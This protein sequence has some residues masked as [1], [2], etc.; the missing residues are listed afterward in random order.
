V[1]ATVSAPVVNEPV[2][3]VL[4]FEVVHEVVFIED[5]VIVVPVLAYASVDDAA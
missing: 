2:V 5:Q 1:V 4:P 3:P